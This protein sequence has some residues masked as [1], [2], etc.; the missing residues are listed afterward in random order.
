MAMRKLAALANENGQLAL[1]VAGQ[2]AAS[3]GQWPVCSYVHVYQ[4][5]KISWLK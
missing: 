4:T 1:N 5:V 2:L 3:N